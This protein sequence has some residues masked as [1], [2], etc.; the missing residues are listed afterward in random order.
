MFTVN[1]GPNELK[2][3]T[4]NAIWKVV[5]DI[6]GRP[7]PVGCSLGCKR[8]PGMFSVNMGLNQPR[9]VTKECNFEG[10]GGHLGVTEACWVLCGFRK[11]PRK[12]SGAVSGGSWAL[13]GVV[14]GHPG[15]PLGAK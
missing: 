6:L 12:I 9:I 7:K 15:R 13:L 3:F 1:M 8:L 11:A 5:G 10:H 14:L 2:N 4:I